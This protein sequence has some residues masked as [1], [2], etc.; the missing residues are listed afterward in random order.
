V[1][2]HVQQ[3]E[4]PPPNLKILIASTPK[5]GNTWL[6]HLLAAIY[7]LPTVELG[8][9]FDPQAADALGERWIMHQHYAPDPALLA[10]A[11]R[12]QAVLITTIRH[13]GDVLLSLYHYVHSYNKRLEFYQLAELAQDD[14]TF[15]A[16]VRSIIHTFFKELVAI[17]VGWKS[18]GAAHVVEYEALHFDPIA[19][20]TNLTS[21]IQSVS[22]NSIERAVERCN[23]REMRALAHENG[24]FFRQGGYGSWRRGLPPDII[25]L[26]R[27]TEPYPAYF[28]ALGYT[29]DAHDRWSD[30]APQRPPAMAGFFEQF[31][32]SPATTALLKTIY[33]SF[34][35]ADAQRRWPDIAGARLPSTFHSWLNQPADMDPHAPA[36]IPIISNLVA[37]IYR[38]RPHLRAD[39]PDPYGRDRVDFAFWFIENASHEYQLEDAYIAP[40]RDSFMEWATVDWAT[41]PDPNDPAYDTRDHLPALTNLIAYVYRQRP[42]LRA[43]F[44]D[45]YGTNRIDV[46]LWFIQHAAVEYH[47]DD[48]Y[49][50]PLR[51]RLQAWA[52]R[53]DPLDPMH[54]PADASA[55][56]LVLPNAV[57]YFYHQRP[58]LLAAFPDLY[59]KH[60]I[61]L[62]RW[63][64]DHAAHD[65]HLDDGYIAP[66]RQAFTLWAAR[67]NTDDA[68]VL[69][70]DS[71]GARARIPVL[72]NLA[73]YVYRS[74]PDL[75]AAFPDLCGHQRIAFLLWLIEHAS[76]E[77]QLDH[78][79]ITPLRRDFMAWALHPGPIRSLPR[80]SSIGYNKYRAAY[81]SQYLLAQK[82]PT[83]FG[84]LIRSFSRFLLRL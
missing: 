41:Q 74:R 17:S 9:P 3:V 52:T 66:L 77:Y 75:R 15:G 26:L 53:P 40:L 13:P 79:C 1:D 20:L 38:L 46:V 25:E 32:H 30:A 78:A 34:E 43:V 29:L 58:D 61:D 14:G 44:P 68:A 10:W 73:A 28:A 70:R 72:T 45:L 65:Y 39:F 22:R 35:S 2:E 64:I 33:L 47:F 84:S 11:E 51:Q 83:P 76:R 37:Q 59:G 42:D 54:T 23:I 27:T 82:Q 24:G 12:N 56:A 69:A 50:A 36:A 71:T 18:T 81:L 48:A 4:I 21:A 67:P 6:R 16:P 7:D 80:I 63:Y 60:R 19:T 8:F 31:G 62:A 57:T 55:D 5:T 49:I